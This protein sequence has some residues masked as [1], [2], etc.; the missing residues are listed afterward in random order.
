MLAPDNDKEDINQ[1]HE[2]LTPINVL[3]WKLLWKLQVSRLYSLRLTY[4]W[5][6]LMQFDRVPLPYG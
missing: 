2:K 4:E 3:A 1:W 6:T 5:E